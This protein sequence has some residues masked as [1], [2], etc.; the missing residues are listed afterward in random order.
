MNW[1][2]SY[3]H[4]AV[5]EAALV[6]AVC[7]AIGLHVL[8]RRLSFFAMAMTHATFPGVVL[9]T[10]TGFDLYLGG[11]AAGLLGCLCVVGVSR[12]R[13][14]DTGTATGIMLAAGFALGVALLSA[15]NG[16]NRNLEAFMTGSLLT[17]TDHDLTTTAGVG[18]VVLL[19][20]G[21]L[22]KELVHGAFDPE[23]QRA[24]GYPVAALELLLLL[25]VEAV[26]VVTTP[27]VGVMLTMS[28]II[29]PAATA[30]LW[31][32]RIRWA[33]PLAAGLGVGA[34][35]I[36]LELSIRWDMAAGGTITLVIAALFLA[37]LA[38]S[39]HGLRAGVQRRLRRAHD[40]VPEES[41]ESDPE[42]EGSMTEPAPL[43][44]R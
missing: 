21:A 6:G 39:P 41:S 19:V 27:A 25:L 40:S 28:L 4:R 10:V 11:A 13:D 30:R 23:G 44:L 26:I 3:A 32:D 15:S 31:T 18:A 17:V 37:S 2:D 24:A 8:L 38:I 5:L 42:E 22:H 33:V 1:L 35:L 36:G 34:C 9:A 12:R 16:F 7:G 14:Q 29:G 20:L 43:R